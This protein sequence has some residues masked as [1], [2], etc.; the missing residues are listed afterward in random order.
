[1]GGPAVDNTV[2]GSRV[3]GRNTAVDSNPEFSGEIT[4]TKCAITGVVGCA[5]NDATPGGT[6]VSTNTNRYFVVS[7]R[8]SNGGLTV[9]DSA[10][11]A[12]DNT[13]KRFYVIISGP[14]D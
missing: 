11:A 2:D 4:A 10:P 12:G 5:P 6:G 13:H 14:Q 3:N 8:L 1:M 7:P 9:N